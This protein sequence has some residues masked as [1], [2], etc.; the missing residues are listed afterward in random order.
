[1]AGDSFDARMIGA[2]ELLLG[3]LSE[4]MIIVKDIYRADG[5]ICLLTAAM[6]GFGHETEER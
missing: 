6:V 2:I 4:G 1:V 3:Q 5:N